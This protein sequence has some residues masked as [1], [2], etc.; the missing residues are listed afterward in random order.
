M[1]GSV[2]PGA[3]IVVYFAP[4]TNRGFANAVLAAVHD[5]QRKPS[6]ISI[7]WGTA[8][9]RWPLGARRL[10]NQS[11]QAAAAMGVSVFVAAGDSG[12]SDGVP[13]RRAHV[14]F[15]ASSPFAVGCGGT[16]LRGTGGQIANET[17]WNDPGD[18]ATGGG[19]SALFAVPAYQASINPTSAN[20][21][22]H[23]RGVPD[24]AGDASPL[25]G[26]NVLVDGAAGPIGGTSAVA[27]LWAALVARIQQQIGYSVAPILPA[28]YATPQAFHDITVGSNGAYSAK[29]G[30]DACTG[31]GSPNGT[32][33]AAA[34]GSAPSAATRAAKPSAR[35]AATRSRAKAGARSS[36]KAG[37]R[38]SAKA[39]ARRSA[40]AP[41][42]QSAPS[43]A[44]AEQRPPGEAGASAP[45]GEPASAG[46]T[47]G[48][49][50]TEPDRQRTRTSR[51]SANKA[52][53]DGVDA[54]ES[55]RQASSGSRSPRQQ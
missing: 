48:V 7:S 49:R 13:G 27:P 52:G 9:E 5:T 32:A 54:P 47:F 6:I 45:S 19:V 14:D 15:P 11:L 53:V 16:H 21:T 18:G 30:W 24:V 22:G 2:A 26:Y 25:T 33:L 42:G 37:G 44:D 8:E 12:S 39:G 34:L 4:N 31:L 29:R 35:A 50:E 20:S 40:R 28:L 51:T 17:V 23:G 36:A 3:T 1:V 10:M 55:S 41:A 43:P 38:P 46:Q